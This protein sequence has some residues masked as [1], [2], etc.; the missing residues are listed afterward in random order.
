[1]TKIEHPELFAFAVALLEQA[2]QGN[3]AGSD[4]GLEHHDQVQLGIFGVLG[5]MPEDTEHNVRSVLLYLT[6]IAAQGLRHAEAIEPRFDARLWLRSLAPQLAAIEALAHLQLADE[7][8][9][10]GDGDEPKES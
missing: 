8:D 7:P 4:E 5:E 2:V 3:H 6:R 10:R 1:M 9:P